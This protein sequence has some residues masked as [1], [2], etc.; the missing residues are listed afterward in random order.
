MDLKESKTEK[1]LEEA[2]AAE[3]KARNTYIYYAQAARQEDHSLIADVFLEIAKN[4]EEHARTQFQ[5][6]G[7]IGRPGENLQAAAQGEHRECAILYPAFA[8]TAR[9]EGF[10]EIADFFERMARMEAAHEEIIRNLLQN[11]QEHSV[12][13]ERTAG[14][15]SVTLVQVM[16]PH[17][18]NRAGNVHGGEIMKLM[19]TAAGVVA[20]RHAHTNVVTAKVE[21]LN[22]LKP[23]RVGDL[24]FAHAAL[25]FVSRSSMEIRVEVETENFLNEE[26][27]KALTAYFIYVALDSAGKPT[28]VPSLLITTEEGKK[29]FAEG[30]KRYESRKGP[31]GRQR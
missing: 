8:R 27:Q 12:P 16:Y 7:K 19:D 31:S 26:R 4:E 14:H 5:F 15:S 21:E 17:Q 6:L 25:T 9:E 20:T 23:V 13:K 10:L 11:L 29:F 18:A 2:F 22:F 24:V 28:R 1:N 30:E 3:S